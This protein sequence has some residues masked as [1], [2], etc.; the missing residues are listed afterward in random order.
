MDNNK[1]KIAYIRQ[2]DTDI[3]DMLHPSSHDTIHTSRNNNTIRHKPTEDNTTHKDIRGTSN[4]HNKILSS[5]KSKDS[6]TSHRDRIDVNRLVHADHK[7]HS[8]K[9]KHSINRKEERGGILGDEKKKKSK[10]KKIVNTVGMSKSIRCNSPHSYNTNSMSIDTIAHIDLNPL[11]MRSHNILESKEYDIKMSKRVR[12]LYDNR[13]KSRVDSSSSSRSRSQRSYNSSMRKQDNNKSKSRERD[14]NKSTESSK[15]RRCIRDNIKVIFEKTKKALEG[16]SMVRRMTRQDTS[17]NVHQKAE[18]VPQMNGMSSKKTTQ[19]NTPILSSKKR[20]ITLKS[21]TPVTTESKQPPKKKKA[22]AKKIST[23]TSIGKIRDMNVS[24]SIN[25]NIVKVGA[26]IKK[27]RSVNSNSGRN[28]MQTSHTLHKSASKQSKS[29]KKSGSNQPPLPLREEPPTT[30]T[31]NE[32]RRHWRFDR[33][34]ENDER[35]MGEGV[36]YLDNITSESRYKHHTKDPLAHVH[37]KS[38]EDEPV[39]DAS[40]PVGIEAISIG[41]YEDEVREKKGKES[42]DKINVSC[43]D[44]SS[45]VSP[46]MSALDI[47]SRSMFI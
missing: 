24:S 37:D 45:K 16:S 39:K 36:I 20:K 4:T 25:S 31:I 21:K 33:P 26:L 15:R 19:L 28:M 34:V 5:R 41:V 1:K 9:A 32:F 42:D 12:K 13:S 23:I 11:T 29:S 14:N 30:G 44:S 3:Q 46:S 40:H 38:S 18:D 2:Y 17:Y 35:S 47:E 27:H 43:M 22:S 7:T 6:D 10:L 8:G